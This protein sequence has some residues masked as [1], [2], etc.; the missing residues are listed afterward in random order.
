[1]QDNTTGL[2]SVLTSVN[3]WP[4]WLE[5]RPVTITSTT[6]VA[7]PGSDDTEGSLDLPKEGQVDERLVQVGGLRERR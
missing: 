5:S 1:M 7:A 3:G 4:G 6:G 2:K